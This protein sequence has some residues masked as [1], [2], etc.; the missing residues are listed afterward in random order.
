MC[1]LESGPS[2]VSRPVRMVPGAR[3]G[4]ATRVIH[5]VPWVKRVARSSGIEW[6]RKNG[7]ERRKRKS[8]EDFVACHGESWLDERSDWEEERQPGVAAAYRRP[9]GHDRAAFRRGGRASRPSEAK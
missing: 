3:A 2:V 4:S 7:P 6:H 5:F 1:E 9:Q 8:L